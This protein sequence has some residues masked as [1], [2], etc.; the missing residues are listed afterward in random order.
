MPRNH[1]CHSKAYTLDQAFSFTFVDCFVLYVV[2]LYQIYTLAQVRT[3][4]MAGDEG[5]SRSS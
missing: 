3:L 2:K 5:M 1:I 4:V